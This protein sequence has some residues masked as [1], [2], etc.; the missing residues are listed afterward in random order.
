MGRCSTESLPV[1]LPWGRLTAAVSTNLQERMCVT[2]YICN[3]RVLHINVLGESNKF[4]ESWRERGEGRLGIFVSLSTDIY[5]QSTPL[6]L[7]PSIS[8]KGYRNRQ[9]DRTSPKVS[10]S[11][12]RWGFDTWEKN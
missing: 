10:Q 9:M 1:S 5:S 4:P 3:Q 11:G 12:D 8:F 2:R 6:L 7:F